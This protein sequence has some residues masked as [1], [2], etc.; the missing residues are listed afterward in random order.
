MKNI[1]YLLLLS[2]LPMQG[3]AQAKEIRR[4]KKILNEY[5]DKYVQEGYR[6]YNGF[7]AD[8]LH[9]Y[10][11]S[12]EMH[13]YPNESFYSQR[14]SPE[15]VEQ[16]KEGIQHH[17]P[18]PYN[19]YQIIVYGK[20]N[21]TLDEMVP[22]N[23][24]KG[25][26]DKK[27]MWGKLEYEGRPWV[28]NVS[29]PYKV[30]RGLAGRHLM[31]TP[32]HGR[33]FKFG[34]WRWQRPF[35]FCTT[36][37]LFTQSFVFPFLIPMLEN[38]GAVVATA[39]ER[40]IQTNE[41]VVD[42]D[43]AP[44]T[45][46]QNEKKGAMYYTS[47]M[48]TYQEADDRDAI[49][50]TIPA[51][52]VSPLPQE[53]LDTLGTT[54]WAFARP[55]GKLNDGINPF[56]L[57]TARQINTA[58]G[59]TNYASAIWQPNIPKAGDYAVYVSYASLP[60]SVD[61]AHY[62]VYH[63]GGSTQFHVNQKMGGGTWVYL[64]NFHFS[65]GQQPKNRV[66][67]TNESKHKGVVTADAVR[68]G[69]GFAQT[70]RDTAGISNLPRFLEASRYYAQWSGMP[71]SLYFIGDGT[72][73]YSD[74]IRSRSSLQNYL[75]GG[76][77]YMPEVEG[78]RVPIEMGIGLHSD[79]GIRRDST[80]YGTMSICTTVKED[81][82]YNY[83]SGIDRM[84]S[85]DLSSTLLSKVTS[86]LTQTY[87]RPWT[88]RELWDRNYGE[89]R[90]PEVPS[91]ILEMLSHQNFEDLKYGHDPNFK[92]TL[93]RAIYK[94]ILQ[95][96][97]HQ[98]G[99]LHYDVQ[100]LPVHNFSALLNPDGNNATLSWEP[101]TD[102]LE[103]SAAPTEYILYT[104]TDDNAFDNG[105]SV[106]N[107]TKI[108]LPIV[109]NVRYDFKITAVN[110][111]GESFPS[112]ILSVYRS[113]NS[114]TEVLIVNGFERVS[115]PARVQTPD[116]VGFDLR[117]DIGVPYHYNTSYCGA[118]ID[119]NPLYA[120]QEGPGAL[121]FCGQELT[122]K[123]IMGNTFDFTAEHGRAISATQRYSYSSVSKGALEGVKN[124]LH[125]YKMVD[126]I[127]GLEKDAN[128]NLRPYK[129]FSP[130]IRKTLSD[131]L[132]NGGR[133]FVSGAYIGSDMQNAEE[134]EFTRNILKYDFAGSAQADSS[135][136]VI[137]L[138][139]EIPIYRQPNERHY[140]VQAPDAI[141][142]ATPE[143]FS[144]FLYGGGQGAGIAYAGNDYRVLA[145]GFPFECIR[146]SKIQ[147]QAM[148]AIIRFLTE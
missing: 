52:T 56:R 110:E 25:N 54:F 43:L 6:P 76:S 103:K 11:R 141:L 46:S 21:R 115:G 10:T 44:L 32:S 109:P 125:R 45:L 34:E 8:S 1:I 127:A 57:G 147:I 107:H 101:T 97:N 48:G 91:V 24:R 74:D 81:T 71:D 90:T 89:A 3:F 114:N 17:L 108:S 121:G 126:Y 9:I 55:E 39:R 87:Q 146:D 130:T 18:A 7:Q 119:F 99:I 30:T 5:F 123:K 85:M 122:G 60:N 35:L 120:G 95:Y 134:R 68:F 12:K 148:D 41:A 72:N 23:L 16:I 38:A 53:A 133:L 132:H 104:R 78:L 49:W 140:A 26:K 58:S 135:E 70:V 137:G 100:P 102:K 116:S 66:V 145:I 118:Q 31:V 124:E 88:R 139:L 29:L 65:A 37:D 14:L 69:G 33:Y 22:N 51:A 111:G 106:G 98:H 105:Q 142:P 59:Q 75:G 47:T 2:L 62:T 129:T 136:T 84:A 128:Y 36:E 93:S 13:I 143:A 73:D 94:A 117:K 113:L 50:S 20:H 86:D 28:T 80:I 92:F 4:V 138:N 15:T 131:Y 27:R 144:T 64:G 77:V 83:P 61:D 96:V 79:A 40:D 63:D 19:K 112:E 67:L 42:N 82:I